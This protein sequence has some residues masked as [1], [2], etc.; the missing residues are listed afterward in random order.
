MQAIDWLRARPL[1][2]GALAGLGLGIVLGL[3]MPIRASAP[4]PAEL[5][6]WTDYQ[7]GSLARYDAATFAAARDAGLL[8]RNMNAAGAAGAAAAASWKLLGIIVDPDPT[9]LVLAEGGKVPAKVRIGE[10]LPDGARVVGMDARA[11][12]F[13]RAGC[14]FE[15]ALYSAGDVA[16][17][18]GCVQD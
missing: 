14:E 15:R 17:A 7:A 1:A 5:A 16:V 2:A 8:G 10:A 12:R 18:A 13:E 6:A 11:L 3:A 9:A 4:D